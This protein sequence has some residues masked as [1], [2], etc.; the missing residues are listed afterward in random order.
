MID[1]TGIN[2]PFSPGELLSS[3]VGLL[4]VVGGFVLLALAFHV[5]PKLITMIAT[6]FNP[7][8]GEQKIR[9]HRDS[10]GVLR[11]QFGNRER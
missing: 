8:Y 1:F 6:A 3:G 11:D 5:V 4:S 9:T 2:L 7:H 10:E